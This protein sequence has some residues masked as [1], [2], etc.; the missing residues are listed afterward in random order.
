MEGIIPVEHPVRI[1]IGIE[2]EKKKPERKRAQ[3]A[4][5][6]SRRKKNV[7]VLTIAWGRVNVQPA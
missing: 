6:K 3:T 2:E 5:R 7:G 1:E 4:L